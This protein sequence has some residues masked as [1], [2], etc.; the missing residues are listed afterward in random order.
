VS[1]LFFSASQTNG[2]KY[3]ALC[4]AQQNGD[5]AL[6]HQIACDTLPDYKAANLKLGRECK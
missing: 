6:V 2:V 4:L 1:F 5:S 3:N